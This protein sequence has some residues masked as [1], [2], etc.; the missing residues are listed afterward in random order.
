MTTTRDIQSRLSALGYSVGP[1][2]GIYGRQTIAA[3][4]Q[5]QTRHDL[6]PDGVVGPLTLA[7]LNGATKAPPLGDDLDPPW[8]DNLAQYIGL[9]EKRDNKKL[10]DYLDSDGETVGDPVQIPWCG[11]AVQTP[12]ALTLPD[13]ALPS[14]PYYALNWDHFGVPA[15]AGMVPK[16]A[17]F[18][19]ERKGGGGHVGFV[20]GHDQTRF[21][22]LAGNQNNSICVA[23]VAKSSLFGQ[24]RWPR[25]YPLPTKGLP[26]STIEAAINATEA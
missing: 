20:V 19:K 12:L 13:E 25:T 7:A 22:I 2:D 11:D 5:F 21:F 6:Q 18:V 4:K 1:V 17:I 24:L 23:A 9:Q 10:R 15:P 26:F 3:V 16:G 8:V 14:N